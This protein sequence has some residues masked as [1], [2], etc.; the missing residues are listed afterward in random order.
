MWVLAVIFLLALVA[1]LATALGDSWGPALLGFG[2]AAWAALI[3]LSGLTGPFPLF[4]ILYAAAAVAEFIAA[5][6]FG[7]WHGH[8]GARQAA[9]RGAPRDPAGD[10][11][12]RPPGE[13]RAGA[14]LLGGGGSVAAFGLLL[15]ITAAMISAMAMG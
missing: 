3:L 13:W 1:V 4:G 7:Q 15:W 9:G 10:P 6:E 5:Y 2:F 14:A 8:Q 11:T 12:S